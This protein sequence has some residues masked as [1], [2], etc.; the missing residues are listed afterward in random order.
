VGKEFAWRRSCGFS[1]E[2]KESV[3]VAGKDVAELVLVLR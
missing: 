1:L 3:E 2:L